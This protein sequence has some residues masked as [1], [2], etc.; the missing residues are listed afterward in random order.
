MKQLTPQIQQLRT[1]L[2]QASKYLNKH[3]FKI[4][5]IFIITYFQNEKHN[6]LFNVTLGY[7]TLGYIVTLGYN[8]FKS[9]TKQF[10]M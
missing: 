2:R 4:P 1:N 7:V 6:S 5:K 8:I 10:T 3:F 9:H